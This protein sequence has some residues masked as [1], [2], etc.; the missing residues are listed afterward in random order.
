MHMQAHYAI[1]AA[2]SARTWGPFATRRYCQRR[3]VPL[4]LYR[5]ARQ[6]EAVKGV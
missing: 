6:L 4:A 2:R 5:L 1:I 3:G